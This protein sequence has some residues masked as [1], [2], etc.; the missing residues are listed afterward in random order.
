MNPTALE[1]HPLCTLFP[2]LNGGELAALRAFEAVRSD[3]MAFANFQASD[4]HEGFWDYQIFDGTAGGAFTSK[5]PIAHEGCA[6]VLDGFGGMDRWTFTTASPSVRAMK[7]QK[8]SSRP[9]G[10]VV[11]FLRAGEFIKV[12]K[13]TGSARNRVSQ[14]KTGCPFKIE[15]MATVPG[16]YELERSIHRRFQSSRAHGEW[17]HATQELIAFVAEIGSAA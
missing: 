9:K 11:Y 17:F 8:V 7:P 1:L 4:I 15:I 10:D 5:R 16:G 6:L 2:R 3:R 12:G 13:A 14:L